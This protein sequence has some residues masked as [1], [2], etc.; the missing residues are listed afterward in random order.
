MKNTRP[1]DGGFSKIPFNV[2][3]NSPAS[4]LDGNARGPFLTA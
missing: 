1:A 4:A 2:N 3:F